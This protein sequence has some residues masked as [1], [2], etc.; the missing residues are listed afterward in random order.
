MAQDA[1]NHVARFQVDRR[2]PLSVNQAFAEE[3]NLP[4]EAD[5]MLLKNKSDHF[6][7]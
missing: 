1:K 3:L 7:V 6:S 4:N 5:G 2:R